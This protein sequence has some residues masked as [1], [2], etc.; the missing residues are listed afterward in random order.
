MFHRMGPF[1]KCQRSYSNEKPGI[2]TYIHTFI[3]TYI[4]TFTMKCG[5]HGNDV[6]VTDENNFLSCSMRIVS[7]ARLKLSLWIQ[8]LTLSCT[9]SVSLQFERNPVCTSSHTSEDSIDERIASIEY[10]VLTFSRS[11]R[12]HVRMSKKSGWI[13]VSRLASTEELAGMSCCARTR[14]AHAHTAL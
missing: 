11:S 10:R 1:S 8:T 9:T 12:L 7:P 4:H 14:R 2:H 6:M 13:I 3:H 5:H